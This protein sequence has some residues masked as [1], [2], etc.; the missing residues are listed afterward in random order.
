[1]GWMIG[2]GF[3]VQLVFMI[4]GFVLAMPFVRYHCCDGPP[5]PLGKYFL[6][7]LTRV[8]PPYIV[9][10]I[11]CSALLYVSHKYSLREIGVHLAASL[12]YTHKLAF[13]SHSSINPVG[14]RL[15]IE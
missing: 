8:E 4:S 14:S 10:L 5:V 3:G 1:M 6:R 15:E 13:A 9:N 11:L 2:G 12:R 7:R